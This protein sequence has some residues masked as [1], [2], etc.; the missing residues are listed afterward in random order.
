MG[1]TVEEKTIRDSLAEALEDDGI[2][3]TNQPV[4]PLVGS[5]NVSV[6]KEEEKD[7]E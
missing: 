4:I 2:G 1:E 3:M 7:I 6:S 5:K